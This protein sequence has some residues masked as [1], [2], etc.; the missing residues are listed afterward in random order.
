M[1][2]SRDKK[3]T[4]NLLYLL[5]IFI[6]GLVSVFD[7]YVSAMY[8]SHIYFNEQNFMALYLIKKYSLY[9]FI[10]LKSVFTFIVLVICYSLMKT[11]YKYIIT[12]ICMFQVCLFLYLNF[13]KIHSYSDVLE[14]APVK[15]LIEDKFILKWNE[16]EGDYFLK[17]EKQ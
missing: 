10:L 4:L 15:K 1:T 11:K 5:F 8:P 3:K 9:H 13:Y 17:K 14:K 2:I 16:D 6:I 12:Y 7:V